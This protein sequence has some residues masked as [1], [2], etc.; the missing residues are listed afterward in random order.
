MGLESLEQACREPELDVFAVH[1]TPPG[2]IGSARLGALQVVCARGRARGYTARLPGVCM[3]A[4]VPPSRPFD[5]ASPQVLWGYALHPSREPLGYPYPDPCV[6]E[7]PEWTHDPVPPPLAEYF[8]E[9][10]REHVADVLSD[11]VGAER[12]RGSFTLALRILSMLDAL[13]VTPRVRFAPHIAWRAAMARFSLAPGGSLEQLLDVSWRAACLLLDR[14][15]RLVPGLDL[16]SAPALEEFAW[17]LPIAPVPASDFSEWPLDHAGRATPPAAASGAAPPAVL[18]CGGARTVPQLVARLLARSRAV[19]EL[20]AQRYRP[21]SSLTPLLGYQAL[22]QQMLSSA[23]VALRVAAHLRFRTDQHR[24]ALLGRVRLEP[25][26]SKRRLAQLFDAVRVLAGMDTELF[27]DL[28]AE[29]RVRGRS[30]GAPGQMAGHR[31]A[32]RCTAERGSDGVGSLHARG[33]RPGRGARWGA[34]GP[35][36]SAHPRH[37]DRNGLG[38]AF[39]GRRIRRARRCSGMAGTRVV[40]A[41]GR[42]RAPLRG[43]ARKHGLGATVVSPRRRPRYRPAGSCRPPPDAGGR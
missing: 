2:V 10:M 9:S 36:R 17:A 19:R 37:R 3:S 20:G 34:P 14:V 41:N 30:Q 13:V 1:G 15:D 12:W 32:R 22:A 29:A 28:L 4:L 33:R 21:A 5:W 43:L 27:V 24:A 35:I 18:L 31:A 6:D 40:V 23:R 8:L 39:Q 11:Q 16:D 25:S 7:R 38:A 26:A 42:W